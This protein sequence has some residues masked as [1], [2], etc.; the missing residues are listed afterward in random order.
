MSVSFVNRHAELLRQVWS[1]SDPRGALANLETADFC[2]TLFGLPGTAHTAEEVGAWLHA[3]GLEV[4]GNYGVRAFA[5]W[6]PRGRLDDPA[7]FEDMLHLE[8][9]VVARSPYKE[10]ARYIQ[11]I[12]QRPARVSRA[13]SYVGFGSQ[14]TE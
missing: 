12:A 10:L 6:V 2:A 9:A 1:K 8:K 4:T 5:D 3:A 13:A 11:L 14:Q 7:F